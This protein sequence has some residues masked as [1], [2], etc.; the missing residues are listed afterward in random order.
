[1]LSHCRNC[2]VIHKD[3][4]DFPDIRPFF[5]QIY[6]ASCWL[7]NFI[8]LQ[9]KIRQGLCVPSM[10]LKILLCTCS[11]R[12]FLKLLRPAD[13]HMVPLRQTCTGTIQH[14]SFEGVFADIATKDEA[15]SV[16]IDSI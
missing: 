16:I 2:E 12:T 15:Y 10:P 1:M 14:E 7:C 6:F 9:E 8:L 5:L 11:E 3:I 13:S 4:K